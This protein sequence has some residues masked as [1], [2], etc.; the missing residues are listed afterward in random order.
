MSIKDYECI[1]KEV[2]VF[3]HT[4]QAFFPDDHT[5]IKAIIYD[6][7]DKNAED[8]YANISRWHVTLLVLRKGAKKWEAEYVGLKEDYRGSLDFNS[9][10]NALLL[11]LEDESA[12]R[13][14]I[15]EGEVETAEAEL[16]SVRIRLSS[17]RKNLKSL[18][19]FR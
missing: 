18:I 15:A 7:R 13:K 16:N 17:A 11:G 10:L 2:E 12:R 19:K 6:C 1:K 14:I 9:G 4:Y 5:N 8:P 3:G